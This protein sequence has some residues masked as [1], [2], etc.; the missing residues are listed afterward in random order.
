MNIKIN[1]N[2]SKKNYLI[3]TIL[4]IILSLALLYIA[5]VDFFKVSFTKKY[6]PI[7]A[8]IVSSGLQVYGNDQ[9][10][11]RYVKYQYN[12]NGKEYVNINTLW[13][14]FTDNNLKENSQ[15]NIYYNINDPKESKVYHISYM[16]II[17]SILLLIFP[18]I[19]LKAR[20]K[21]D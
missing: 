9:T 13:W 20:L 7:K 21:I 17:F 19:F 3:I 10:T 5:T 11:N 14:K 8:T 2:I 6:V 18:I 15:I 1:T 16:L 4:A 12:V